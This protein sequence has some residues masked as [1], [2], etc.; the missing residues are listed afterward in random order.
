MICFCVNQESEL[1]IIKMFQ[2]I[3]F[4]NFD[5]EKKY[6]KYHIIKILLCKLNKP[7]LAKLKEKSL[8]TNIL[9]VMHVKYAKLLLFPK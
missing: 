7:I 9:S 6:I 3:F 1:I 5:S 8:E 4:F 2:K